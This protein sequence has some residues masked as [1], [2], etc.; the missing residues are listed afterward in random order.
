MS[1]ATTAP[2][3]RRIAI[4]HNPAAGGR[5]G[6]RLRAVID[7]LADLGAQP[8]LLPTAGAGDATTIASRLGRDDWDAVVAAGGDGTINEV[9][10]GL[11]AAGD[12]DVTLPLGVI[13]LG[14]ANVLA[15]ELGLP[16]TAEE[17]AAL[18]V[19]GEVLPV[20]LARANDRLLVMMAGVGFDAYVCG[21]VDLW[22]KRQFGR[23]AYWLTTVPAFVGFRRRSYRVEIDGVA[24]SAA[25]LVIANGH[26]YGGRYTCAPMARL[27]E[28]VV[29]VCLFQCGD[30]VGWA[31]YG[32]ALVDGSLAA[33]ADVQIVS[34]WHVV[35]SD[36]AGEPVQCD[37]DLV[38]RLPLHL[39]ADAARLPVI[40]PAAHCQ[41]GWVQVRS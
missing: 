4:I 7:R 27:T 17:V 36:G 40:A 18:L 30:P 12:G 28:P 33:R 41:R 35:V 37:G 1:P 31:R 14:T 19:H 5:S 38:T 11:A 8:S 39:E 3:R 13:P 6:K 20:H 22:L 9:V 29:H 16:M 34:G 26:A 2:A 21:R 23:G 32:L 24:Y 25:S 10:N 15:Y